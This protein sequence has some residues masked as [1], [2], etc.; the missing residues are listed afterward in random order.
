MS[1]YKFADLSV[2]MNCQYE[3]MRRRSEKYLTTKTDECDILIKIPKDKI[4]HPLEIY[5]HLNPAEIETILMSRHFS[6][7][8]LL[9]NGFSLHASAISFKGNGILFSAGSGTGKSTHTRLWQKH[10]GI[11]NVP[12]INDDKPAIRCIKDHF[13]VYGTPFS[14]NSE[15]NLDMKVPLHAIVFLQRDTVNSIRTLSSAEAL[16]LLM[17][18]TLRP[19]SSNEHMAS[20]LSLLNRLISE[21]P[22]YMLNCNMDEEVVSV[23]ANELFKDNERDAF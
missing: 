2:E 17:K 21:I 1:K 15:E 16:P 11:D 13:Y 18:Q 12:I 22:L 19:N 23:V 3:I 10:F 6:R 20:L 5:K 7:S 8:L 9:H 4:I 14:G